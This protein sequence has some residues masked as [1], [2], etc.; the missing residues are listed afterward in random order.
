[1]RDPY[2]G[3]RVTIWARSADQEPP[4]LAI[5][6]GRIVWVEVGKA[7]PLAAPCEYRSTAGTYLAMV[8]LEDIPGFWPVLDGTKIA[9]GRSRTAERLQ[10]CPGAYSDALKGR[11]RAMKE[12]SPEA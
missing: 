12:L 11:N 4:Y 8:S 2:G 1:M 7:G 6:N 3:R 10:R 5:P 9:P